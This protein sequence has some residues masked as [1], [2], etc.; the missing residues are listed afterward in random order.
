MSDEAH[1]SVASKI[2]GYIALAVLLVGLASIAI[3][4]AAIAVE[5]VVALF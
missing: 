2:R 4:Y 3:G 5:A 1:I